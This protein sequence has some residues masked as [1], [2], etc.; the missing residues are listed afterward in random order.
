MKPFLK[1]KEAA[2]EY[3]VGKKLL[4]KA[5]Q[6]KNLKAYKPNGRDLLIKAE[7]LARW[8]ESHPA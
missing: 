4:Y 5:I 2:S 6:D 3:G 8:I 1:V 7:E